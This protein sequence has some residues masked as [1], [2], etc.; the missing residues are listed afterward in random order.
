MSKWV[1]IVEDLLDIADLIKRHVRDLGY[2]AEVLHDGQEGLTRALA[3]PFNL[4]ILDVMLPSLDGLEI[5][6]VLRRQQNY[7]PILMLTARASEIDRVL[8][9]ELGADD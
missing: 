3:K 5:C 2:Q 1:L 7:T 4:L 9:L 8:G 6:R